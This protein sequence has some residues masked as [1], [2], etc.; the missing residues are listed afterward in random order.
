MSGEQHLGR[1]LA[2]MRPQLHAGEFVFVTVAEVPAGVTPAVTVR[3]PEGLTLVLARGEADR[4]GLVYEYVA[5]WITLR[6]HSALDAVGLTAAVATELTEHGVSCNVVA[7]FF[8]D[9][10]FVPHD[11]GTEVVRVLEGLAARSDSPG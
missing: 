9:H 4:A 10:L 3:E 2:S 11:R 1:L 8:H 6:V 7:G 5:A